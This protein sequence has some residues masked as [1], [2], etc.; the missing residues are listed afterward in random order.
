MAPAQLIDPA[1]LQPRA[2]LAQLQVT[3]RLV[4]RHTQA[5][6]HALA[7]LAPLRLRHRP[8]PQPLA[9]RASP[10]A[11][12]AAWSC[13]LSAAGRNILEVWHSIARRMAMSTSSRNMPW[14]LQ[15]HLQPELVRPESEL[16]C[17]QPAELGLDAVATLGA[18]PDDAAG[19]VLVPETGAPQRVRVPARAR[20]VIPTA[21]TGAPAECEG[22]VN[23]G[24][25]FGARAGRRDRGGRGG[26]WYRRHPWRTLGA[27]GAGY[28]RTQYAHTMRR[29][30]ACR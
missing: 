29:R 6:Q 18:R 25:G 26:R 28:M 10:E 14:F 23:E 1:R 13:S 9:R 4:Q 22:A 11:R 19:P 30:T 24:E 5:R 3:I 2:A 20:R 17:R 21:A 7:P 15:P 27:H 12:H 8:R 16:L